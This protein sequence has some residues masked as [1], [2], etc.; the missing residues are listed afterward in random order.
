MT[1]ND[2]LRKT[3]LST[4]LYF[5]CVLSYLLSTIL[6]V[7]D[8]IFSNLR[9]LQYTSCSILC[10]LCS[11]IYFHILIKTLHILLLLSF[12]HLKTLLATSPFRSTLPLWT[13]PGTM[14][15]TQRCP[16]PFSPMDM[17]HSPPQTKLLLWK[18]NLFHFCGKVDFVSRT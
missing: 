5:F 10:L 15:L 16:L 3:K 14:D 8:G 6:Y 11:I 18:S 9:R 4:I 1:V 13:R 17:V 12:N 2:I 7:T